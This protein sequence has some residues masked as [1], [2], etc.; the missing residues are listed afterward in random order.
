MQD[1]KLKIEVRS[2]LLA[3]SKSG[4]AEMNCPRCKAVVYLPLVYAGTDKI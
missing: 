4:K 3:V 2:R 1:G